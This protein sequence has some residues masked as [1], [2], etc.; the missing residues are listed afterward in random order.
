MVLVVGSTGLL[1]QEICRLLAQ[2][3]RTFRALVRRDADPRKV[4]Q[5]RQWGAELSYGDL[6]QYNSLVAAC[7]DVDQIISTATSVASRREGDSIESVDYKG[8]LNL[9]EAADEAGVDHFVFISFREMKKHPNPLCRAKRAVEAALERSDMSF[10]SLQANYFMEVWLSPALGFDP[11]NR[12]ARIYGSGDKKLNWISF[13]DV[14][15]FAVAAL[16]HHLGS[17][18]IV[19]IGG[20]AALSPKEVVQVFEQV[21]GQS[22]QVQHVPKKALA[23]QQAAAN[24]ALEESFAALM[25]Q[26]ADGLEMDMREPLPRVPLPLLSVEDYARGLVGEPVA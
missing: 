20:P 22:F 6:K 7:R 9:I 21:L 3:Q 4:E 23:E 1:G 13:R 12:Q 14:A 8:Q 19:E 11:V 18:P 15:R 5:L 24:N 25:L 10:C 2:Q 16:D 17:E 26:V